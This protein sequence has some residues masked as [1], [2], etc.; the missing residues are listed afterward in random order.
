M[1][2]SFPHHSPQQ[3]TRECQSCHTLTYD[4]YYFCPFCGKILKPK[5]LSTSFFRQ[6]GIYLFSIFFPP[7]GLWPAYKYLHEPSQSAKVI[8][9]IAIILTVVSTIV[10]TYYTLIFMQSFEVFLKG[11]GVTLS[12][13]NY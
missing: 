8:A 2:P 11:Q 9:L 1:E 12:L 6:M 3:G 4:A 5:P 10:T 7:L 13:P